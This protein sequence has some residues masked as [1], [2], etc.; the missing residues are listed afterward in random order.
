MQH[1]TMILNLA[2]AT[3][4]P[5]VSMENPNVRKRRISLFIYAVKDTASDETITEVQNENAEILTRYFSDL[6]IVVVNSLKNNSA[7][8]NRLS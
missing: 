6:S 1:S 3:H 8:V 2:I 4:K 5:V 7:R